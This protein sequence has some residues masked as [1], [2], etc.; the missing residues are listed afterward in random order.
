MVPPREEPPVAQHLTFVRPP[1]ATSSYSHLSGQPLGD[2]PSIA[3]G[4]P[5]PTSG[6][7]PRTRSGNG[8]LHAQIRSLQRQLQSKNEEVLQ[9][10][11]QL[12]T[13]ENV[14]VGTLSEKLREAKRDCAMWR[15]RAEAAE[16]RIAVFE[17]FAAKARALRGGTS[18]GTKEKREAMTQ[19]ESGT[20]SMK[21]TR[22]ST[23]LATLRGESDETAHTEDQETFNDRL[24]R[25]MR[26]TTRPAGDG[27][28]SS[29]SGDESIMDL[30]LENMLNG[31]DY[32]PLTWRGRA[33]WMAVEELLNMQDE[34]EHRL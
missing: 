32:M 19:E 24:R 9:L 21:L 15:D 3:I 6:G 18:P 17:K 33:L 7:S 16:K 11:R 31:T 1:S 26:R 29:P 10:R 27:A 8:L 2:D 4:S 34:M 25:S 13:R 14:D 5:L 23:P 20:G 12:E 28:M 30:S 22:Q